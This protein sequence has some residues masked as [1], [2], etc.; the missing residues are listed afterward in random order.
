MRI[1]DG[2]SPEPGLDVAYDSTTPTAHEKGSAAAW[3]LPSPEHDIYIGVVGDVAL[4]LTQTNEGAVFRLLRHSTGVPAG[5]AGYRR[6]LKQLHWYLNGH[7]DRTALDRVWTSRD[8]AFADRIGLYPGM[9]VLTI[10]PVECILTF[11]GSANNSI[12]RNAKMVATLCLC[13]PENK[14]GNVTEM[15]VEMGDAP[16]IPRGARISAGDITTAQLALA[17]VYRFPTLT[18]LASLSEEEYWTLG[19]GYRAPRI[20]K[21][22]AQLQEWTSS[23]RLIRVTE[24][25]YVEAREALETLVGVG[26][27]V[28]DCI[29]LIGLRHFDAIPVDTHCFQFAQRY[30]YIGKRESTVTKSTHN[31]VG[32]RLREIFGQSAGWAFMVLFVAEVHPFRIR[33]Q[34][35]RM[36]YTAKKVVDE[37]HGSARRHLAF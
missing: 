35:L 6:A 29:C 34:H 27:K 22:I 13:F 11:L 5:A 2:E 25:G 3:T 30:S 28:A 1:R 16:G 31:A 23:K 12:K 26:R 8:A 20:I 17:S 15:A 18:Q 4:A 14:I 10:E 21:A 19:W 9:R 33:A 7:I 37:E 24:C 32:D 36:T